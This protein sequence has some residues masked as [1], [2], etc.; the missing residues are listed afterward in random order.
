MLSKLMAEGHLPPLCRDLRINDAV[1]FQRTDHSMPQV[2][3]RLIRN[4]LYPLILYSPSTFIFNQFPIISFSIS[5]N[6]PFSKTQV[7]ITGPIRIKLTI[8][9]SYGS[10]TD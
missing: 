3:E 8:E 1:D 7:M 6:I 10:F 5:T 4:L 9:S 2:Q